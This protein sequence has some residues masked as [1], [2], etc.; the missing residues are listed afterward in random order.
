MLNSVWVYTCGMDVWCVLD[1]GVEIYY[2]SIMVNN[3]K[4]YQ[5]RARM[6]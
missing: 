2:V 3:F 1:V 5:C 6:Q 4:I